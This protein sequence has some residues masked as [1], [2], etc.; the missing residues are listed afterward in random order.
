MKVLH[1]LLLSR[2][3]IA[4]ITLSCC[5]AEQ[6]FV[7]S[8]STQGSAAQA[9]VASIPIEVD[10]GNYVF[11]KASVNGSPLTFIL[12]SGAGSGLVLYF[13]AAQALGDEL[14]DWREMTAATPAPA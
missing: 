1:S 7:N 3:G 6:S 5:V 14:L 9:K 8:S 4:L 13:K 11:I 2:V 12:D 10:G